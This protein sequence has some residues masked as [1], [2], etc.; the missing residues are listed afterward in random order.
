MSGVLTQHVA[1]ETQAW[2]AY[3]YF[4]THELADM[5]GRGFD[6]RADKRLRDRYV[7]DVKYM[8]QIAPGPCITTFSKNLPF[9]ASCTE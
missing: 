2:V 9:D 4:M 5:S 6:P 3:V 8:P 7:R 1:K